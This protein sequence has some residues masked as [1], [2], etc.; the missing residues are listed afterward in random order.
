[1]NVKNNIT[2][3]DVRKCEYSDFI[4]NL[5]IAFK[6]GA[7]EEF[8]N[9]CAED[10][11]PSQDIKDSLCAKGSKAY[12]IVCDGLI[13]GGIVLVIDIAARHGSLDLLFINPDI[14][15]RGIGMSAWK[16]VEMMYPEITVWE[17]HTPYF[18]KRNIHFYVNK[19]GFHIVEFYNSHHPDPHAPSD[20]VPGT[21]LFFRFEKKMS[22]CNKPAE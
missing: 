13:V 1:M 21:D 11:I 5:Q 8:G 2:F 19:C 18:E 7:N 10:I 16:T 17:T 4:K 9:C 12:H 15:S 3:V 6:A 20:N 22:G 14:H